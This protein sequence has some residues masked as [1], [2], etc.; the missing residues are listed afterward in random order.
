[1]SNRSIP[2]E[3]REEFLELLTKGLSVTSASAAV[4]VSR[5]TG[6]AWWRQCGLVDLQ[7]QIE[8]SGGV[9][10]TPPASC[11]GEPG[12]RV[13]RALSSEDRA[14]I[15]AG[16]RRSLSLSDIGELIGRDKSVISREVRRNRGADGSY[17][18]PVAH[19]AAH[20]AR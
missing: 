7:L 14:V 17:W 13:R 3:A 12:A 18:G 2:Y 11:P 20:E 6:S 15:A 9:P 16:L 8:G 10:G 4:G 1:M 5:A 19:R